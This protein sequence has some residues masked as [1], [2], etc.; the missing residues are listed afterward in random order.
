[1]RSPRFYERSC[2]MLWKTVHG[3]SLIYQIKTVEDE[4][5]IS[6]AYLS[7]RNLF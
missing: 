3:T 6:L 4:I 5:E 7:L 2:Q 1:M